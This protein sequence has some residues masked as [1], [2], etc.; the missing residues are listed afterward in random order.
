MNLIN[1]FPKV[2]KLHSVIY[3]DA[4]LGVDFGNPKVLVNALVNREVFF[5]LEITKMEGVI[6]LGFLP[7][8]YGECQKLAMRPSPIVM[9]VAA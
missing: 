4:T 6:S 9:V 5:L 2:H 3:C 8:S 1:L 7:S